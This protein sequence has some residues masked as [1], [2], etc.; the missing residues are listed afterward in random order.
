MLKPAVPKNILL[1]LAGMVWFCA[2]TMLLVLAY[3]WL[4]KV[5]KP[6]SFIYFGVGLIAALLIHRFGFRKIAAK[7]INRILAKSGWQCLFSCFAWKS[8]VLIA[9]MVTMGTLFR[10]SDFPKPYLAILYTAIGVALVLSS[11]KYLRVFIAE[12]K[13]TAKESNS[14]K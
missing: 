7:N 2:G 6:L 8:Y 1:L 11:L 12:M 14:E 3:S 4:S 10:R 5:D 13:D 9:V